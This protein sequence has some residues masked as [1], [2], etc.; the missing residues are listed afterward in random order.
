MSSFAL[1][2]TRFARVN[3][4]LICLKLQ[5]PQDLFTTYTYTYTYVNMLMYVVKCTLY[6]DSGFGRHAVDLSQSRKISAQDA[7][8]AAADTLHISAELNAAAASLHFSLHFDSQTGA[9]LED[10]Q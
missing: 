9:K 10:M 3:A 7:A 1:S 6:V 5:P 8:A 4:S 2:V